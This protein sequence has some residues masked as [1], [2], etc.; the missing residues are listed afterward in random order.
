MGKFKVVI[1]KPIQKSKTNLSIRLDEDV[2]E[3]LNEVKNLLKETGSKL[4]LDR[5]LQP[6]IREI[7][8]DAKHQLIETQQE[9]QE[10]KATLL[11][12]ARTEIKVKDS[13]PA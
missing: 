11:S 5:T 10:Q 13:E 7:L 12:Q 4:N 9:Q 8:N 3:S 2:S 1:E 6:I